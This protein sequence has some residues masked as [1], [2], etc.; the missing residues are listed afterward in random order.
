[1]NPQ[2]QYCVF[3]T[4]WGYFGFS[5]EA[6][7]IK[8]TCLPCQEATD[9]ER[10]LLGAAPGVYAS[11]LMRPAQQRIQAYFKGDPVVFQDIPLCHTG[12]SLFC[13]AVCAALAK[14]PFGTTVTYA[15]LAG[16]AGHPDAAR[17]VG[18]VMAANPVPLIV[19]CHRV[20]RADGGLGGFSAQG[21]ISTKK[22]LLEH[23]KE[24]SVRANVSHDVRLHRDSAL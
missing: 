16:L 12:Q 4:A 10:A 22:R 17:A 23:E 6:G 18:R 14:V 8:R 1:M 20:V 13:Q 3:S 5:A 9:V 7:R 2:E 21:G 24:I 19:P 15:K 11:E